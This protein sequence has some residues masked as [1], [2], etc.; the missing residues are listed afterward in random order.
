MRYGIIADIHAN[1]IALE[2][3]LRELKGVEGIVCLGDLVGYGPNPNECVQRIRKLCQPVLMGNHDLASIGRMDLDWFNEYARD[4]LLWTSQV[5]TLENKRY[6][7]GLPTKE[8][9]LDFEIVHGSLRSPTEEYITSTIEAKVSLRLL[10]KDVLFIGHTHVPSI[11]FEKDG[12]MY[13]ERLQDKE[14]VSLGDGIKKIIN[15]GSVGQPRDG[16]PRASFGILDTESNR[17]QIKRIPYDIDS[18]QRLMERENLPPYL[19]Q[20]LSLGL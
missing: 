4:A 13:A 16:D 18:V 8:S 5:L 6:L 2:A 11:F 19:I 17:V 15:V 3:V 10:E 20:R 1:E 7:E 12:R 9:F 14:E